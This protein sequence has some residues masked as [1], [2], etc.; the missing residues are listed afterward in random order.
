MNTRHATGA[1]GT[2]SGRPVTS[3]RPEPALGCPYCLALAQERLAAD[4]DGDPVRA[5]DCSLRI[6]R[7]AHGH[8]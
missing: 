5:A 7:H 8:S 3:S 6:A 4:L 1:P 2:S